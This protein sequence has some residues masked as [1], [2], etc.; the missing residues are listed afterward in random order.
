MTQSCV[1]SKVIAIPLAL[2]MSLMAAPLLAQAPPVVTAAP[3]RAAPPPVTA[4]PV[5]ASPQAPPAAAPTPTPAA[6]PPPAAPAAQPPG[7]P[8]PLRPLGETLTGPAKAEYEAAKLLYGDGDFGGAFMKFRQAYVL[9]S[10]A[11]LL[12]NLAVC[13]KNLRHY[14]RVIRL[15]EQ[16]QTYGAN[17]TTPEDR[18]EASALL[19]AVRSF[20]APVTL[21][22]S[23]PGASVYVDDELVGQTPVQGQIMVDIGNRRLKVQKPGFRT[24]DDIQPI[25]G[26]QSVVVTVQLVREIH[27]GR[28]IITA[29]EGSTIQLDGQPIAQARWDGKVASGGHTLRVIAQGMRPYQSEVVIKDD[30]ARTLQISLEPE[31][32]SGGGVPAWVWI[33]GG[34]LVAGGA[35]VGGYFLLKPKSEAAAPGTISPGVVPAMIR[36]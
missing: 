13:E 5:Q 22:V 26:S 36:Y 34:V 11:R 1:K 15:V 12:W 25:T 8:G 19:A 17:V 31:Q 27:E 9:S 29:P 21:Q 24:F 33:G 10:D 20:V 3:V 18:Q 6:Q 14:A 32:K 16:Y 4:P 28:L 35:A 2:G 7:A 30:E 23:E